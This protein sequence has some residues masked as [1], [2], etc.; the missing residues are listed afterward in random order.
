MKIKTFNQLAREG[1][2]V[3]MKTLDGVRKGGLNGMYFFYYYGGVWKKTPV[4]IS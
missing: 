1:K 4:L 2:Q 3:E